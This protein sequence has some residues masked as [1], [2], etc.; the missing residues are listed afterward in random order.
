MK[1]RI[2]SLSCFLA[3]L[4]SAFAAGEVPAT[5]NVAHAA[6]QI[7]SQQIASANAGASAP[8]QPEATATPNA[9]GT[10]PAAPPAPTG[11]FRAVGSFGTA[12]MNVGKSN[13]TVS[14]TETDWVS[15][16]STHWQTPAARLG[17]GYVYPIVEMPT[18]GY[19]ETLVWLPTVEP[20]LS[21]YYFNMEA[22]GNV[23]RFNNPPSSST[24]TLPVRST[25]F[26]LDAVVT[27]AA[28]HKLS[29]F[30]LGGVGASWNTVKYSDSPNPG[31]PSARPPLNLNNSTRSQASYEWGAGVTYSFNQRVALGLEYLYTH[32]GNISTSASGTLGGVPATGVKPAG[33]GLRTQSI[34]LDLY[35]GV[36]K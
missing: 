20:R 34:L 7:A 13:L 12:Q 16:T 30:V 11:Y 35:V 36:Y 27:L 22:N 6:S 3:M 10:A 4:N 18:K 2:L 19:S 24:F 33:F 9:A 5:S 15:Q 31:N 28:Y 17:I 25:T 14:N 1:G 32:M 23:L 29:L 26:M 21:V 8:V